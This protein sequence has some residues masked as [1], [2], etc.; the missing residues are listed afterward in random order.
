VA[1]K[2]PRARPVA[3]AADAGQRSGRGGGSG[4]A[5]AVARAGREAVPGVPASGRGLDVLGALLNFQ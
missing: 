5:S 2:E 1:L 3:G 4:V